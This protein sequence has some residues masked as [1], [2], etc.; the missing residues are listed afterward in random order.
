MRLDIKAAGEKKIYQLDLQME[1]SG[2]LMRGSQAREVVLRKKI[3]R[4][5]STQK[6]SK[7]PHISLRWPPAVL[8][9]IA[10]NTELSWL[11][12]WGRIGNKCRLV[13][14]GK[15][16]FPFWLSRRRHDV[17]KNLRHDAFRPLRRSKTAV[18]FFCFRRS[19]LTGE[20]QAEEKKAVSARASRYCQMPR[21]TRKGQCSVWY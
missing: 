18:K 10:V 14:G 1:E 15:T 12:G 2:P 17:R 6:R 3:P 5:R 13:V 7:V 11:I 20:A 21:S 8:P 16:A 9:S 19:C 4:G